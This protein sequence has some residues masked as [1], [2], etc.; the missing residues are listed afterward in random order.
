MECFRLP[1][2]LPLPGVAE[3]HGFRAARTWQAS[4]LVRHPKMHAMIV[5][6]VVSDKDVD[7][8]LLAC[9]LARTFGRRPPRAQAV[10]KTRI[11]WTVVL[12]LGCSAEV[13]SNLVDALI[14][15]GQLKLCTNGAGEQVWQVCPPPPRC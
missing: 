14:F 1:L 6:A 11:Q 8:N 15:R 2:L 3:T 5:R 13:A 10:G 12:L 9:V 4:C 7:L